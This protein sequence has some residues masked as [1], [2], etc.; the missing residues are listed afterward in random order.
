MS[1][2]DDLSTQ[3]MVDDPF[4]QETFK[5]FGVLYELVNDDLR[6]F[7]GQQELT[8][9]ETKYKGRA[10]EF[11]EAHFKWFQKIIDGFKSKYDEWKP[12]LQAAN[13]ESDT[14]SQY[15]KLFE[16]ET[17][18]P[19]L[20]MAAH[21]YLHIVHDLSVVVADSLS[22]DQVRPHEPQAETV[23]AHEWLNGARVLFLR[24]SPRFLALVISASVNP[25]LQRV[26]LRDKWFHKH[27][28][29]QSTY[30][31]TFKLMKWS[32]RR[33]N[34][35]NL[36]DWERSWL[37]KWEKKLHDVWR[38]PFR[39]MG[40]WV[41]GL[42]STAWVHGEIIAS[43]PL[44]QVFP[45]LREGILKNLA[46]ALLEAARQIPNKARL[47]DATHLYPPP[48]FALTTTLQARG[49]TPP[50]SLL[51]FGLSLLFVLSLTP[52]F[53]FA[54]AA[55][56]WTTVPP[57]PTGIDKVPQFLK[58]LV[59]HLKHLVQLIAIVVAA[60]WSWLQL[61]LAREKWRSWLRFLTSLLL[62]ALDAVAAW[63]LQR[64]LRPVARLVDAFGKEVHELTV[65]IKQVS[66]G[67]GEGYAKR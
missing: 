26:L 12:R 40:C 15:L 67:S 54:A 46:H 32:R 29:R 55:G 39:V 2:C 23:S 27:R 25:K 52:D 33:L 47:L 49:I 34:N 50:L 13:G 3:L 14:I 7:K 53:A 57:E 42:R 65:N 37:S 44:N 24:P 41:I 59:Q 4:H 30:W 8:T 43:Q 16:G 48:D 64:E 18:H 31:I 1:T 63:W 62:G 60:L 6:E 5:E 36:T 21:A 38:D 20:R 51:C 66:N 61:H 9:E 35:T 28:I 56:G 10:T 11:S 17:V 19:V 45:D 22:R 58:D